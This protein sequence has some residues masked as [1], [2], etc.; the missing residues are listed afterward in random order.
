MSARSTAPVAYFWGDD[1]YGLE[2]A[3]AAQGER[4]ADGGEPLEVRQVPGEQTSPA[5]I[6]ERVGTAPM[7]SGGTLVVV[8][9]PYPLVRAREGLYAAATMAAT[10][11]S[12]FRLCQRPLARGSKLGLP[13]RSGGV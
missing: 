12:H 7:F 13:R 4:L 10:D 3:A 5:E 2:R 8:S 9:E 6:N 11:R 1:T